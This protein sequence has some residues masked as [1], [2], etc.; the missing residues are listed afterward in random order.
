MLLFSHEVVSVFVIS[1]PAALQVP[2]SSTMPRSLLKFTSTEWGPLG[3]AGKESACNGGDLGS[4]PGL[5]RSPGEGKGHPLQYSGLENSMDSIVH[6]VT[7][8]WT[9]LSDFHFSLLSQWCYLTISSSFT[10]C[11]FSLQSIPAS[12][13]FV[14]SWLFAS[15]GQSIGASAS[16]SNEYSWLI[17]F[18][19]D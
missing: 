3:S 16:A 1:W 2:L 17:S 5:G 19:I 12:R 14:M 13:S 8:N 6:G 9:C 10:P 4:V 7:K 15:C 11:F 18:R